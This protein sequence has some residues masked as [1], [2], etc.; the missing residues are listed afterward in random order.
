M[1]G[2][3]SDIVTAAGLPTFS[4]SMLHDLFGIVLLDRVGELEERAAGGP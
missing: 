1:G 3:S 4:D 2:I